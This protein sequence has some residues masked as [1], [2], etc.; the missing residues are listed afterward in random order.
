MST[1]IISI[2]KYLS[3][4]YFTG[5]KIPS[6]KGILFNYFFFQIS[7]PFNGKIRIQDQN[8]Q[9]HFVIDFQYKIFLQQL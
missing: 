4:F 7:S 2:M 9:I 5:K 8:F 1:I 6:P 3:I